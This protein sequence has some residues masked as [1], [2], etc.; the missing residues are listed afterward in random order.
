ML[1]PYADIDYEIEVILELCTTHK[2]IPYGPA[3]ITYRHAYDASQWWS[4]RGVGVFTEGKLHNSPFLAKRGD[5][6]IHQIMTMINGRPQDN[7]QVAYFYGDR[8]KDPR[9]PGCRKKEGVPWLCYYLGQI[10]K[11]F[12][13]EGSAR[14]ILTDGSVFIGDW[15]MNVMSRGKLYKLEKDGTYTMFDVEYN[16]EDDYKKGKGPSEQVPTQKT[17]VSHDHRPPHI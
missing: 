11:S 4:F 8:W 2:G 16:F 10:D 14:C 6:R 7:G 13:R 17:L 5:G 3:L 12:K 9:N 1:H 15:Q